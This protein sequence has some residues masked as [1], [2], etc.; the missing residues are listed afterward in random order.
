L[1]HR[2]FGQ[3]QTVE[4]GGFKAGGLGS[5]HI[6]MICLKDCSRMLP[7]SGSD[8]LQR[9]VFGAGVG[10]GHGARCLPGLLSDGFNILL[11]IHFFVPFA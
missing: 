5:R 3:A 7:D 1:R 9:H 2:F 6:T 4:H 11:D 10:A 8:L